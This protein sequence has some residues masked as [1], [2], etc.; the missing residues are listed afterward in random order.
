MIKGPVQQKYLTVDEVLAR[1]NGGH[2]I[3]MAYLGKV[4]REMDRPWG[5]RKEKKKSWGIFPYNGTWFWKDLATEETGSAIQFVERYFGLTFT[6]AKDKICFDFGLG[7]KEVNASPIKVTWDKPYVD[8]EY[9][10]IKFSDMPFQSQHSAFWDIV[11][12]P[13]SHCTRMNCFAVK[14]A[15]V[16]GKRISIRPG[17]VVFAFYA[18]EEDAVKLYFP[19]RTDK[20]FLNNISYHYLWNYENLTECEDLIVQKSPKDMIVTSMIQ[21][22]CTATQAEAVKIFDEGTV[23]R[24]NKIS[25]NPWIWYGSDWDGVKKCKEI[26]DTH[27]W[28]YVN[29]PKNLLPEINDTYSYTAKYKLRGLEEFMKHKKLIS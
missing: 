25:M 6:K 22:C 26:T 27:K 14:D 2:D 1:T 16:N 28:R 7:G 17:E 15:A 3:F 10:K 20:R 8:K 4:Y 29:T 18:A 5:D 12:V 19:E 13:E 24:I 9:V 11:E 21:P 23:Q